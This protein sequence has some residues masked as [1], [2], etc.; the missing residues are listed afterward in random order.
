[1]NTETKKNPSIFRVFIGGLDASKDSQSF[2]DILK[3]E[4]SSITK[5][6]IPTKKTKNGKKVNKGFAIATMTSECD[7]KSIVDQ[8]LLYIDG[9]QVT[10]KPFQKGK[11]LKDAKKAENEKRVFIPNLPFS[12]SLNEMKQALAKIFGP[13]ED[14]FRLQNPITKQNKLCA[15]CFFKSMNDARESLAVGSI[16]VNNTRIKLLAFNKTLETQK[17]SKS[18]SKK[19]N[20]LEFQTIQQKSTIEEESEYTPKVCISKSKI[21]RKFS[22]KEKNQRIFQNFTKELKSS[23]ELLLQIG[24]IKFQN[25]DGN[26]KFNESSNQRTIRKR[27]WI[28][29]KLHLL[30]MESIFFK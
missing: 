23:A 17:S 22:I 16:M 7:Y 13:V 9:R 10:A 21:N 12:I 6:S 20:E 8:R 24:N 11:N 29:N 26:L 30:R 28:M 14:L 4:Y 27:A 5:V 1:M 3:T 19:T 18:D 25:S 15:Y 2:I